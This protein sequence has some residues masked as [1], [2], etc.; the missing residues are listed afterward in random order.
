MCYNSS[1]G[2]TPTVEGQQS[3]IFAKVLNREPV[4][5]QINDPKMHTKTRFPIRLMMVVPVSCFGAKTPDTSIFPVAI[6][7]DGGKC[8]LFDFF[9][10]RIDRLI[11]LGLTKRTA[12]L[13]ADEV[14]Q[15]IL[16]HWR[17]QDAH[18]PETQPSSTWESEACDAEYRPS[19]RWTRT[20]RTGRV[21]K[22]TRSKPD[23]SPPG[24]GAEPQSRRSTDRTYYP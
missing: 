17:S 21:R 9:D 1:V 11:L 7:I 14:K 5:Y 15:T 20:T 12:M 6:G 23:R 10:L 3:S 8:E 24:S 22:R 2:K 13:L 4:L 16:T 19:S 18:Q